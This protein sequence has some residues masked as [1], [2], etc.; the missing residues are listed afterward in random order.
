MTVE[1]PHRHTESKV[2]VHSAHRMN[3]PCSKYGVTTGVMS[4]ASKKP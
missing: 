3:S 4:V 2:A 1:D